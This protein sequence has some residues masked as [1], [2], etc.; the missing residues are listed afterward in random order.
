L[1]GIAHNPHM[2]LVQIRLHLWNKNLAY[3]YVLK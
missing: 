1:V 3:L 2:I